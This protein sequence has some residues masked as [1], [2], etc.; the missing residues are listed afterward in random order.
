MN[1]LTSNPLIAQLTHQGFPD[2]ADA[3]CASID[4]AVA[5]WEAAV[6]EALPHVDGLTVE[7]VKDTVPR[8]LAAVAEAIR[9]SDPR[10]ITRLLERA[11]VQ[12]LTRFRQRYDLTEL[13]QEDRLLRGVVV[14]RAELELGRQLEP[15]E[16]A[17]L[18]ATLDVMLQQSSVALVEEQKIAL[19]AAAER[20]LKYLAFLSHDL[21]NH[22]A[23]VMLT[24][25]LLRAELTGHAECATAVPAAGGQLDAAQR[26]IRETLDGMR[27]LLEHERLRKGPRD[28]AAAAARPV[29]LR[30]LATRVAAQHAPDA[31]AKHLKLSIEIPAGAVAR[32][33]AELVGLVLQ[34]LIGNAVKYSGGGGGGSGSGKSRGAGNNGS[35]AVTPGDAISAGGGEAATSSARGHVRIA[36]F[37]EA[38]AIA[39]AGQRKATRSGDAKPP[40]AGTPASAKGL[41]GSGSNG[42]AEGARPFADAHAGADARAG[43]WVLSVSD[44]GPGIR[45]EHA[46]RIFQAFRRGEAHGQEGVGLGLAIAA[47]AAKL[48]EAELSVTSTPG[49]GTTF[50]LALPP[51]PA[52]ADKATPL[53]AW[54]EDVPPPRRAVPGRHAVGSPPPE[55]P[56]A[57]VA[58]TGPTLRRDRRRRRSDV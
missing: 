20:E 16:A 28:R 51:E 49:Q 9:S 34:N 17:A 1:T 11:P 23:A 44:E 35:G 27:R 45:P 43:R 36:G 12:G 3:I 56:P 53:P 2:L 47:Q 29:D 13:M 42:R 55:P 15:A 54:D 46:E 30:D 33:D 40:A 39:P 58:A 26:A 7:E 31:A 25:K 6:R 18:H 14:A 4:D 57:A 21:Q 5:E 52:A 10:Q 48:L 24:L 37:V 50:R 32:T 38:Q 19:R 8:I 22:L 41:R